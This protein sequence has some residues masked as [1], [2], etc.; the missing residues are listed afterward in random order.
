MKKS[1]A[2]SKSSSS[3]SSSSSS[4]VVVAGTHNNQIS[5][6]TSLSASTSAMDLSQSPNEDPNKRKSPRILALTN[7]QEKQK[8]IDDDPERY[9]RY[10]NDHEEDDPSFILKDPNDPKQK[11][12]FFLCSLS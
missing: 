2:P 7:S 12:I 8:P 4:N 3:S 1:Q 5:S 10:F 11:G 6:S 9:L